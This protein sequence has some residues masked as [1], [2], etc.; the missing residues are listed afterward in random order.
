MPV[1]HGVVCHWWFNH[2]GPLLNVELSVPV[3]NGV[4]CHWWFNHPG[5]LL[6]VELSVP[7]YHGV[8]CHWWFNHPGPLLNVEFECACLSGSVRLV[9][10][11]VAQLVEHLLCMQYVCRG[12]KSHLSSYFF[13]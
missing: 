6:N 9:A 13:H 7:V 12:F 10:V 11:L 4:V 8:V 2:P 3:Y 1:Y 5:P